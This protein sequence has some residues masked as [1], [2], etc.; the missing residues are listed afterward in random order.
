MRA[1]GNQQQ[2]DY[3]EDCTYF[4]YYYRMMHYNEFV[5]RKNKAIKDAFK[6]PSSE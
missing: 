6:Q 2:A 1:D 4:D 5:E 3:L